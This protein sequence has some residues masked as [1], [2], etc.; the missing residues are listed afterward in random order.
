MKLAGLILGA[1]AAGLGA[2]MGAGER[3]R[4]FDHGRYNGQFV[5]RGDGGF[6]AYDAQGRYAGKAVRS[7]GVDGFDIYDSQNRFG[8]TLKRW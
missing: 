3:V 7:S 4:Q 5:S 1:M 2:N 8:V 6:D